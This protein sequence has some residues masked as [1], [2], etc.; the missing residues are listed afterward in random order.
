MA[1]DTVTNTSATSNS[2]TA[3][4]KAKNDDLSQDRFL[5]LLIAQM[6]S[7]DPM[8]PMDNAQM[9]S[10]LAQISTVDGITKLND[11]MSSML[12]QLGAVDQL[13]ATSMIGHSVLIDGNKIELSKD[14][15]GNA[16]SG[17]AVDLAGTAS[18]VQIQVKDSN[19]VIIRTMNLGAAPEGIQAFT[20]DGKTDSGAAAADGS[21]SFTSTA[22]NNGS[23]VTSKPLSIARVDGVQRSASGTPMLDLGTYGLLSQAD[24]RQV[25]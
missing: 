1:V 25:F 15:A 20:W 6:Q 8:N 24:I 11:T 5:T 14:S 21:Y 19:G 3:T 13:N 16:V 18:N 7:Q 22:T 17:A 23:G 4:S 2:S 10:Q 9:T 12:T